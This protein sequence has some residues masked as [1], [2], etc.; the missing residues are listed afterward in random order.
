M[1]KLTLEIVLSCCHVA[2]STQSFS[3]SQKSSRS[4][5]APGCVAFT[6]Q[7]NV[8]WQLLN[9]FLQFLQSIL[10]VLVHLRK[11][12]SLCCI[13]PSSHKKYIFTLLFTFVNLYFDHSLDMFLVLFLFFIIIYHFSLVLTS[14]AKHLN[15]C[16]AAGVQKSPRYLKQSGPSLSCF[17]CRTYFWSS[18]Q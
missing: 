5:N 8:K 14:N 11:C 1:W 7:W 13:Y 2:D 6:P 18:G 15:K 16:R 12:S 9:M 3:I 17:M 4:E 10:Q